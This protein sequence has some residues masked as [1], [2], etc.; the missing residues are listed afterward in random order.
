MIYNKKLK[1]HLLPTRNETDLYLKKP[2]NK[3]F[4]SEN[5]TDLSENFID[6]PCHFY[7]TSDG[8]INDGDWCINNNNRVV[9]TLKDYRDFEPLLKIIATTD[10]SLKVHF[11]YRGRRSEDVNK[12]VYLESL[13]KPY[14]QFID[15]LIEDYNKNNIIEEVT[16]AC[17]DDIHINY[18]RLKY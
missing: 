8:I 7:F 13:D 14:P 16:A 9:K 12:I 11:D 17:L 2:E 1:V 3:L 4:I 15:N 18:L 10:Q 6:Q 5:W